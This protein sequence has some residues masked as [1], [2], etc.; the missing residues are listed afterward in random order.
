MVKL[1]GWRR[2]AQD[3]DKVFLEPNCLVMRAFQFGGLCGLR[4]I[5]KHLK[6]DHEWLDMLDVGSSCNGFALYS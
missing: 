6:R 4:Q 2:G 5:D 3:F 1:F